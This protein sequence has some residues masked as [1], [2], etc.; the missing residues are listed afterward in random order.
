MKI[1]CPNCGHTFVINDKYS[2]SD[3]EC[4][5]CKTV[6]SARKD[7]FTGIFGLIFYIGLIINFLLILGALF[8]NLG[9]YM[10]V[11]KCIMCAIFI[12]SGFYIF[13]KEKKRCIRSV[14]LI[15]L[16]IIFNP[17]F[18]FFITRT[19]WLYIDYI[20]IILIIFIYLTTLIKNKPGK[21]TSS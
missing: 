10:F 4:T 21:Q 15:I 3:F 11:M 17:F 1:T 2:D 7:I 19:A 20:A 12:L 9:A 16:A 14:T 6:F 13:T 5:Q 8:I 18:L